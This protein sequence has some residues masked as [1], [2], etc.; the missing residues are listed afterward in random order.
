[1][2][3]S[4]LR[5]SN[6]KWYIASLTGL[7]LGGGKMYTYDNNDKTLLKYVYRDAGGNQAWTNPVLFDENGSQGPFFWKV[8]STDPTDLYYIEVY[9]SDNV[10]QWTVENFNPNEGGSGS[11]TTTTAIDLKN[12]VTNNVMW[13]NFGASANPIASTAFKIAS[14][15]HANLAQTSSN[16]GPDTY[17]LK[18]NTNATDQLSFVDFTLG[19]NALTGD[20]TPT[21]YLKYSCTGIGAGETYK[22]VQFPITQ[23]VQNLSNAAMTI[24][25]W[26][27]CNS[28]TAQLALYWAQFYGDG[29]G[30]AGS[31]TDRT[32]IQTLT[33]TNAWVKYTVSANVPSVSGKTIGYCANDG[34]FMQ[35]QYPLGALTNI[36]F[37][38]P[39]AFLGTVIPTF[40]YENYDQIDAVINSPRTGYIFAS[41]DLVAPFGYLLMNDGTIGS[42]SSGA[43]T[44]ANADTF[45]LY[46]WLWTNVS[47]PSGNTLCVVSGGALGA[48]AAAD[49][50]ANK[51]LTLQ[52]L[53]GR[54]LS[55][56]GAGSGLT[57][58]SLG[59]IVGQESNTQVPNHV[60]AFSSDSTFYKASGGSTIG[61]GNTAQETALVTGTTNN[62]TGGVA[63][64]T[65]MQPSSFVN[66]FIKL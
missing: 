28:G 36:D 29:T 34:L 47:S 6:P 10:L 12:Y 40:T 59:A 54:A 60:H 8:D 43:T 49:F 64:V 39:C 52:A 2:T 4:Y 38:K 27:R 42:A 23:N 41:Y 15:A 53:M 3:I 5:T 11:S 32:L 58:R 55:G 35:I 66:F 26:A 57:S 9:D 44:R 22:Y 61:T 20:I 50:S 13:R 7:P 16:Y 65:N 31:A 46:N 25:I 14:G 37:T 63:S 48:S 1:M 33:L 45:P 19:L 24:S 62:N 18:N 21:Q 17:F 56:A 30:P 51:T